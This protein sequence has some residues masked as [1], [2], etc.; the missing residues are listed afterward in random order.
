MINWDLLTPRNLF[1]IVVLSLLAIA[2]FNYF[3]KPSAT[4]PAVPGM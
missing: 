2:A 3:H 1:V 4:A